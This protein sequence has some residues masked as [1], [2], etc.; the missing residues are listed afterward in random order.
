MSMDWRRE[1]APPRL[2]VPVCSEVG[3]YRVDHL[4]H[5]G[6]E[7]CITAAVCLVE[8]ESGGAEDRCDQCCVEVSHLYLLV[9]ASVSCCCLMRWMNYSKAI[10]RCQQFNVLVFSLVSRH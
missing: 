4:V 5:Q 1:A 10:A 6:F 2:S 3:C 8:A 9:F 7:L